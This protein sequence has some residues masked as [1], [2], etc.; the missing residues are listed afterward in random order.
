MNATVLKNLTETLEKFLE[1][2]MN[3][4]FCL[5]FFNRS[6]GNRHCKEARS[7]PKMPSQGILVLTAKIIHG[8]QVLDLSF[9]HCHQLFRHAMHA[10]ALENWSSSIGQVSWPTHLG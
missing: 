5:F 2:N 8:K 4:Y 9:N 1:N 3:V 10:T 7:I 6:S